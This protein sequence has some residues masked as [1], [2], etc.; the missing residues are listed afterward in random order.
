MLRLHRQRPASQWNRPPVLRLVRLHWF[1]KSEEILGSFCNPGRSLEILGNGDLWKSG[2]TLL[3]LGNPRKWVSE[4]IWTAHSQDTLP[5]KSY[6]YYED[7]VCLQSWHVSGKQGKS[8][9]HSV[10]L[11]N[12]ITW[13]SEESWIAH[14]SST[15]PLAKLKCFR[16]NWRSWEILWTRSWIAHSSGTLHLKS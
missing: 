11:G 8:H 12:P 9:E 4:R 7:V 16:K 3:I 2:E 6:Q 1:R 15:L 14:S 13:V 10:I 5:L